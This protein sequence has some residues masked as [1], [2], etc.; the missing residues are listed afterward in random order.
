MGTVYLAVL[1]HISLMIPREMGHYGVMLLYFG[2]ETIMPLASILATVI[3]FLMVFWRFLSRPVKNAWKH[4]R[5]TEAGASTS[6]PA[7]AELPGNSE[8]TA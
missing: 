4:L 2:P 8:K 5:K 6:D 3:G 7:F 1:N